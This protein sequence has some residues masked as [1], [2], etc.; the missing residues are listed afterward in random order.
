MIKW[1]VR[2]GYLFVLTGL[3][4]GSLFITSY[5]DQKPAKTLDVFCWGDFLGEELIAKFEEETH[6][7]VNLHTCNSN[8][9]LLLK[10]K[11]GGVPY[12]IIFPSDYAAALLI[13]NHLLRP[14]D[15][16][17]LPFFASLSKQLCG[18]FFDRDNT[19][20]VPFSW[21]A[22]LIAVNKKLGL[23]T[24]HVRDYSLLFSP[25][26]HQL[27]LLSSQD[28]GEN[29]LT[30]AFYLF[31]NQEMLTSS[32]IK[33]VRS[34]LRK[35]RTFVEAYCDYRAKYL[36]TKEHC[37]IGVGKSCLID[38]ILEENPQIEFLFPETG[39]FVSLENVA[40]PVSAKA[41]EE[42]IYKFINFVFRPENMALHIDTASMFPSLQE[43]LLYTRK[44]SDYF[45]ALPARILDN[46]PI[47]FYKLVASPSTI[48]E[49]WVDVKS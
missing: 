30:A 22:S 20:S 14:L 7:K 31:G 39:I 11:K 41:S 13:E 24:S 33:E 12:D 5:S 8:E 43:S 35:Q 23:D 16:S 1:T 10:M 25:P 42:N 27:K 18:Q 48:R 44:R 38:P 45:K 17:R 47:L 37:M 49:V 46:Y 9:E 3:I 15:K 19:Y 32:Q 34:L 29:F 28:A 2:I 36:F 26:P 40:V 4:V 6:I 21:E